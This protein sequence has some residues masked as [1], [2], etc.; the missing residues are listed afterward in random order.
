MYSMR[1]VNRKPPATVLLAVLLALNVI[2]APACV[3][4]PSDPV[5]ISR[6]G[7]PLAKS[8]MAHAGIGTVPSTVWSEARVLHEANPQVAFLFSARCPPV[9][10][11]VHGGV[12]NRYH[13][14]EVATLPGDDTPSTREASGDDV[15]GMLLGVEKTCGS[16]HVIFGNVGVIY[17]VN[18][19]GKAEAPYLRP[20]VK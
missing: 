9:Y 4:K 2:G 17:F 15:A 14:I 10:L 13:V 19:A 18:A 1:S 8:L 5:D 6:A 16:M 12:S 3:P 11:T 20:E 7:L